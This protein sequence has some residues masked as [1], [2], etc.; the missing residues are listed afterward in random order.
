VLL[1]DTD[2][3]RALPKKNRIQNTRSDLLVVVAD[4]DRIFHSQFDGYLREGLYCLSMVTNGTCHRVHESMLLEDAGNIDHARAA[5]G[6]TA[7][8]ERGSWSDG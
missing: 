8:W 2:E 1:L 6:A 3:D 4:H 5:T 7:E